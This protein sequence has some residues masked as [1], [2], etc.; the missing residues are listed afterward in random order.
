MFKI[1]Q[2]LWCCTK[3]AN[4]AERVVSCE[5]ICPFTLSDGRLMGH[6]VHIKDGSVTVLQFNQL[7]VTRDLAVSRLLQ[8]LRARR[9]NLQATIRSTHVELEKV[10]D[11]IR[12][13]E[14][15]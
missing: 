13:L 11:T 2:E 5:Y 7:F 4:G 15:E 1:G 8:S 10:K 3:T 9:H 12:E 6:A 14:N